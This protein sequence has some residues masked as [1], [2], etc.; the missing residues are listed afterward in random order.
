MNRLQRQTGD[1]LPTTRTSLDRREFIAMGIGALVVSALPFGAMRR[2]QLISRTIPVM[3]T[4]AEIAVV[5]HDRSTAQAAI[6]DAI[7]ALRWT[8]MHISRFRP[9]SEIGTINRNA[10]RESV[11]VTRE[12]ADVVNS[13]MRWANATDGVFD[14]AMGHASELWNIGTRETPPSSAEIR[15]HAG[16]RLFTSVEISMTNG[17]PS[18]GLRS[19]EAALD[20]GGIAKG[21]G[22]DRAV[23]A[24]RRH[25]IE[26]ALVS[27]GG[28]LYALGESPDGRPWKIGIRSP[29]DPATI[30][31]TFE[32]SNRA[33]ATS[34]DYMQYF[35]F[36]GR[37]YHHLLDP[38]T[39]APV[40]RTAS[41]VTV[42][43][44]SCIDADA[45]ATAA[46]ALS[47]AEAY[48][49]IRSGAPGSELIMI[50]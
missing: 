18:V 10:G 37:R 40:E 22:V 21:F 43:A 42:I 17:A 48:R 45:G 35:E 46:F 30:D 3:G 26:H 14:P 12:T 24:L 47:R 28:D 11:V 15:R 31:R 20:L 41:S 29:N 23:A 4:I 49:A 5:H 8:D 38:R 6:H 13:A 32:L 39:G 19:A 50:G 27:A 16:R 9:D 1:G 2:H 34:G 7:E 36:G 44:S 25:G 33:V